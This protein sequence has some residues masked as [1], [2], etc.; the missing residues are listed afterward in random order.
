MLI[1]DMTLHLAVHYVET[2]ASLQ[3]ARA[4]MRNHHIGAVLVV[5]SDNSPTGILT[6]YDLL[7]V[8]DFTG[9]PI[10]LR[11]SSELITVTPK[12]SVRHASELMVKH[13]CHHLVVTDGA[14][15]TGI[16]SSLDI[17]NFYLQAYT[18]A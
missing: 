14:E 10:T 12:D 11:M 5:D 16:V 4:M 6:S 3:T 15:V 7:D 18:P 2:S 1:E 9:T 8:D 17:V 13:G